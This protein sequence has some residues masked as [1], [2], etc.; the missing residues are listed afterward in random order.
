MKFKTKLYIGF[1]FLFGLF[2]IL[3]LILTM[4]LN[5][6]YQ[7]MDVI[8]KNYKMAKLAN[9]I[10]TEL[11][12]FSMESRGLIAHPPAEFESKFMKGKYDAL[13]KA[14]SA[15]ISLEKMNE[16][17]KPR[18]LIKEL[19]TKNKTLTQM[20]KKCDELTKE[21]KTK[22]LTQLYWYKSSRVRA[23]MTQIAN[24][25]QRIQERAVNDKI[26]QSKHTYHLAV[27]IISIYV[28]VGL[29][30]GIII[31][32]WILRNITVNLNRVTSVMARVSLG[33]NGRLPR[34]KIKSKDEIGTIAAAF[35]EMAES[36]EVQAM[37]EKKLKHA[38]EEQ[39]WLKTKVTEVSNMY[40]GIDNLNTLAHRF[41]TKVTPLVEAS[42]GVF[43]IKEGKG[44]GQYLKKAASYAAYS[45]DKIGA[46]EFCFGEGIVGQCAAD[47]QMLLLN[48]VPDNYIK[49]ASGL[50][51]AS[52]KSIIVLPAEF[53][54]EV[55]AVVELA[56]LKS[57][58]PLQQML[59]KEVISHIG[60]TI[61]S[62]LRHMQVEQLLQDSQAL[63]E[64]LQSQSEELQ[65]QH[66]ELRTVNEQLED[67]YRQSEQ[68]TRELEKTR[69]SLEEKAEQLALNSQY[70]SEFLANM[71][72]ELRTPLNSLLILAQMLADNP[73][74]NLTAKQKEYAKTIFSS[75][76]DLLH[77]INDILD[78]TKVQSGKM[79]VIPEDVKLIDIKKFVERRFKPC[80][81]RENVR[82]SV[83]LANN[84]PQVIKT[85]HQRLRQILNNLL[86]N[87]FKFTE[88]GE[89]SLQ[90]SKV[91][92]HMPK[93]ENGI[94]DSNLMLAFAVSDTGIGIPEEKQDIIFEAFKQADGTTSRKYGG[95]GLGL[96]ISMHIAQLL[97][98]FIDVRSI[99]GEG[100]T[101]TLYLPNI[102][103][104][105]P[106][107]GLSSSIKETAA[108]LSKD[109]SQ[110]EEMPVQKDEIIQQLKE[111][112]DLLK[113][114]K[115]LIVDDD[116]RNIFA[117]TTALET[118]NVE[119]I[120]AEN[121]REGINV[122]KNNPDT[123][124][125]LMDIMMPEIDGFE[126]IQII[127]EIP[128]C[129]NIPIIALTAKAMKGDR[130]QCIEAGA[131]DYISKPVN[132]EQLLSIIRVWLYQ[133]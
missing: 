36:L 114:K 43:Y 23:E 10:Q 11:N 30:A 95:T 45:Q 75:G 128:E 19:K 63:T 92:E 8:A 111:E 60:M 72:H 112:K 62:I 26:E 122:L 83:Q 126:A 20:E 18:K 69:Q 78:L 49:I 116:M 89:V 29:L 57:F 102:S 27:K 41:I 58:T 73:E 108:G 54:G 85:D 53:E 65:L 87:A 125:I 70:K 123:D 59:L 24:E 56:S 104:N 68:K 101:F 40:P 55:L 44:S 113:G 37:Q 33:K 100:S 5:E 47:N 98:G 90:I 9:T 48:N 97:G 46:K 107:A 12:I 121:G 91:Q 16:W 64:E 86:S 133:R 25:L 132:I 14:N 52:P 103:V 13:K 109:L 67:Q 50:G 51:M 117:L 115:I 1:G 119:V 127:R 71:S 93:G 4:M 105:N 80:A 94:N 28:I 129:S 32:V 35:N 79:E 38:A 82:F 77:L 131:S 31:T 76:N 39:S 120:F 22:E 61:K 81:H 110:S 66:E 106:L 124:L 74:Q 21:G 15:T 42:Y 17:D 84:L 88:H 118:Y 99:E 34:I 130:Q 3:Q 6:L 7:N 2:I 96:S